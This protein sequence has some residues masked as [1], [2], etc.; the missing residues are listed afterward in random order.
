MQEHAQYVNSAKIDMVGFFCL[1][2]RGSCYIHLFEGMLILGARKAGC[3]HKFKHELE[4][5]LN[6][7]IAYAI[8]LAFVV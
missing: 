5:D 2:V 7:S 4:C 8:S 6:A 3:Q 1:M